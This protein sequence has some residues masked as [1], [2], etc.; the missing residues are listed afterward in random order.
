[1]FEDTHSFVAMATEG[2][3]K[4]VELRVAERLAS[5]TKDLF[6]PIIKVLG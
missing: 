5:H 6:N 1:M 4:G 3:S 2:A